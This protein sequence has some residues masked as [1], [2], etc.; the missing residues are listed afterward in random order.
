MF[1]FVYYLRHIITGCNAVNSIAQ[2]VIFQPVWTSSI[3]MSPDKSN[4]NLVQNITA[5]LRLAKIFPINIFI[6][7][8]QV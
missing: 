5:T 7:N 3:K 6:L 2:S 8:H 1:C 4:E